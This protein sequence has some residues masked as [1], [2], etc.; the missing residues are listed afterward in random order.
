METMTVRQLRQLC[1][2]RGYIGFTRRSRHE[3]IVF[4]KTQEVEADIRHIFGDISIYADMDILNERDEIARIH[5]RELHRHFQKYSYIKLK[6]VEKN[7]REEDEGNLG[8]EE[9][10]RYHLDNI[11]KER[12]R[13]TREIL[14]KQR[15]ERYDHIRRY[16]TRLRDLD[17]NI[18]IE[19]EPEPPRGREFD[20]TT[21]GSDVYNKEAPNTECCICLE[22]SEDTYSTICNH[23]YHV[24]CMKEW[25]IL[26]SSCPMYRKDF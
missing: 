25:L 14:L 13:I 6:L 2:D 21:L 12:E 19:E 4:I 26:K 22:T 1:R 7:V 20:F 18:P 23:T 3:L 11:D 9:L 15:E 8:D 16:V 24:N 10:Y 5:D 17:F